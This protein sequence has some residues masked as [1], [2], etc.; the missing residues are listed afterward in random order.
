[1]PKHLPQRLKDSK[2]AEEQIAFADVI[3]LN[4]TDLV[5]ADELKKVEH[6]IRHINAFAKIIHTERCKVP[7][8][9]S[10]GPR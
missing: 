8:D 9:K 5:S 10:P 4:K 7:L 2:E 3:L 1:M 6:A